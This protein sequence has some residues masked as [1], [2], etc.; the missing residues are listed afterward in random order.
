VSNASVS[1]PTW[2]GGATAAPSS[3][4]RPHPVQNLR[5]SPGVPQW[6]QNLDIMTPTF[7]FESVV[8]VA[9]YTVTNRVSDMFGNWF[10]ICLA[11]VTLPAT[12][13]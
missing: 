7:M 4:G 3:R 1:P 11:V 10:H 12:R 9:N 5:P 2:A 8:V 6:P 13:G